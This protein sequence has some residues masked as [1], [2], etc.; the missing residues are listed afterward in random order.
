VRKKGISSIQNQALCAI[1]FLYK[2]VLKVETGHFEELVWAKKSRYIPVVFTRE[3][4]RAIMNQ[5]DGTLW[6]M[7]L[8]KKNTS[9]Y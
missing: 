9:V 5:L 3:E 1:V 7:A 6:M 2:H 8:S 4:V